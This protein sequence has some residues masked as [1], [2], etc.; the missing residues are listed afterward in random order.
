MPRFNVTDTMS[1]FD[2]SLPPHSHTTD[3]KHLSSRLTT[4]S[5]RKQQS[6]TQNPKSKL[7]TSKPPNLT[8][9]APFLPFPPTPPSSAAYPVLVRHRENAGHDPNLPTSPP[10][11]PHPSSPVIPHRSPVGA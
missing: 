4:I 5:T 1:P 11:A 8:H 6:E 10:Q 3:P 2:I 7:Q 9:S